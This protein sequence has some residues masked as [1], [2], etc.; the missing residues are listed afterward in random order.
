MTTPNPP[1]VSLELTQGQFRLLVNG[2]V[3]NVTV[4][5]NG[6][7]PPL[8]A[9]PPAAA[10]APGE[11]LPVLDLDQ[12]SGAYY[13]EI[14]QEMYLELGQLAKELNVSLQDLSLSD[15][16]QADTNSPG[17][18]FQQAQMQLSDVIKM[19]EKATLNILD[20]IDEIRED[21][22]EVQNSLEDLLQTDVHVQGETGEPPAHI[23]QLLDFCRAAQEVL[24][25]LVAT[26]EALQ[27]SLAGLEEV[28][29]TDSPPSSGTQ[30]TEEPPIPREIHI[31]PAVI[32]Q[33]IYE[34]CTNETVKQHLKNI[35]IKNVGVIDTDRV[36]Q[37]LNVL[38]QTLVMEDNFLNFP[39]E[40]VLKILAD[41]CADEQGRVLLNKM[42]ATSGKIFLDMVLPMEIPAGGGDDGAASAPAATP[43]DG[44]LSQD[45]IDGLLNFGGPAEPGNV[46][47][48]SGGDSLLTPVQEALSDHVE[49]LQSL[50]DQ[51]RELSL[52][53][54][55]ILNSDTLPEDSGE[56]ER[57]TAAA[58]HSQQR[59][60]RIVGTL[61][62]IIE[63]LAFQDLSGQRLLKVSKMLHQL[64]I[65]LL[66][67]LVGY[68]VKL[69]KKDELQELT[70]AES[71]A[72]AQEE[73]DRLLTC[74]APAATPAGDDATIPD[75]QP[76]D[77]QA[78]NDLL[79][80]LGF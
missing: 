34:F 57:I 5:P 65:Q 63:A 32:L 17:E 68:G 35:L 42:A 73:I 23:S 67:M 45:D 3:L 28:W 47:A 39:V 29:P 26:G 56:Y 71:E 79:S 31:A 14:S 18:N 44:L 27:V 6:A 46:P 53:P 59:M 80:N 8:A 24:P 58:K 74:M 48:E 49:R 72:M 36:N 43:A 70:V 38:S 75:D 10:P 76:L 21:C 11:L 9:P 13:K 33:T 41:A 60:Q 55:T 61:S 12:E 52:Q 15:L 54:A 16:M 69:K 51:V 1:E 66:T 62:K 30:P 2:V 40:P 19:T 25:E 37:E 4:K 78:V 50:A 77:Q 64:Q 7:E 20:S 22:Q